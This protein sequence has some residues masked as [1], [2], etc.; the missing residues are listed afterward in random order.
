MNAKQPHS[1]TLG[2]T[3]LVERAEADGF[4]HPLPSAS[5]LIS[6]VHDRSFT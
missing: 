1:I 2:L 3:S 4:T 6:P 5:F